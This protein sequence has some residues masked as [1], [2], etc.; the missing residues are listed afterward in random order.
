[1][2]LSTMNGFKKHIESNYIL[3][4]VSLMFLLV[5]VVIGIYVV[6]YMGNTY[7]S[8]LSNY[9]QSFTN[10][11]SSTD[12]NNKSLFLES[13]KNNLLFLSV[14]YILGILIVGIPIIFICD[15]FKGFTLGFSAGVI[16]NSLGYKGIP[17]ILA[18]LA[19]QNIL[20]IPCIIFSSVFSI[21]IGVKRIRSK[22]LKTS[23]P[24]DSIIG[25]SATAIIIN[26]L[27]II[28]GSII[29]AFFVPNLLRLLYK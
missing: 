4:L 17:F 1:M 26:I 20:Y 18:T 2:N 29:E 14:I 11:L 19:P 5:G 7:K 22:F 3:Y 27:V 28:L 25:I 21:N 6:K 10:E 8:D 23:N 15:L 13:L 24:K 16:V 12:I 9:L